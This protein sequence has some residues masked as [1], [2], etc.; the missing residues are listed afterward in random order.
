L[1]QDPQCQ[2]SV[3]SSTQEDPQVESVPQPATQL[4]ALQ[5]V[6][7]GHACPHA[8]QFLPSL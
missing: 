1:P 8:P 3:C 4:L 6:L 7:A 5:N 2:G